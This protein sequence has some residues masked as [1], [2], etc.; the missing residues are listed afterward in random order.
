MPDL[1]WTLPPCHE[2][3]ITSGPR[4]W[5]GAKVR[6]SSLSAALYSTQVRF[7]PIKFKKLWLFLFT[8]TANATLTISMGWVG[9]HC[10]ACHNGART[11]KFIPPTI[12]NSSDWNSTRVTRQRSFP[13]YWHCQCFIHFNKIATEQNEHIFCFCLFW[14]WM[15]LE[16]KSGNTCGVD[17]E[18]SWHE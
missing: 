8:D 15:A 13:R 11:D 7:Y 5:P 6:L 17:I 2:C 3:R 1:W 14:L 10:N 9:K 16:G 12:L 18:N 4:A